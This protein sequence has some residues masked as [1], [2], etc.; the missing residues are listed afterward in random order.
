[1]ARKPAR[2]P[3]LGHDPRHDCLAHP[4]ISPLHPCADW[5]KPAGV[6]TSSVLSA[7]TRLFEDSATQLALRLE[8]DGSDLALRLAVEA[9][10]L[11]V[12]FETWT[13]QRPTDEVRV[14]T[15]ERLFDL[16]RRAMDYLAG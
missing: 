14:A 13:R 5:S 12:A 7:S 1:M 4:P 2:T 6:S 10:E 11:A 3:G 8:Q 9:R 15:I 16:N